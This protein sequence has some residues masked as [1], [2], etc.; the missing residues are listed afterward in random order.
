MC[1]MTYAHRMR[2][3]TPHEPYPSPLQKRRRA[4]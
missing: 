1:A 3:L 2:A 4:S